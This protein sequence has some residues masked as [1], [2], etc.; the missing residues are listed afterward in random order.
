MPMV[1]IMGI[2]PTDLPIPAG[3]QAINLPIPLEINHR[4]IHQ[5]LRQRVLHHHHQFLLQPVRTKVV[6]A[7]GAAEVEVVVA[8]EN[9]PNIKLWFQ[10]S[11]QDSD[12][13]HYCFRFAGSQVLLWN[14]GPLLIQGIPL[15]QLISL[16]HGWS[17]TWPVK[18]KSKYFK[19]QGTSGD[20][21]TK[22]EFYPD[23][24]WN[25]E[26]RKFSKSGVP[27]SDNQA[28]DSTTDQME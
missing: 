1:I 5:P 13:F 3:I 7:A 18:D 21:E 23:Q 19:L 22:Q 14:P 4:Q 24:R 27:V 10:R 9:R 12:L 26:G 16:C 8:V 11:D 25:R 20:S 6:A 17:T 28:W 2:M 15:I